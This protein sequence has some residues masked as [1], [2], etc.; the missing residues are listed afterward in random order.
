MTL[1]TLSGANNYGERKS[2][3]TYNLL[4]YNFQAVSFLKNTYESTWYAIVECTLILTDHYILLCSVLLQI[5]TDITLMNK[6]FIGFESETDG[7][8]QRPW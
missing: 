2:V 4:F 3:K 1:V 5:T 7:V 6:I 8:V